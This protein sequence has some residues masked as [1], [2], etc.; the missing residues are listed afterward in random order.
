MKK[1]SILLFAVTVIS[2]NAFAQNWT[3]YKDKSANFSISVPTTPTITEDTQNGLRRV[4][5]EY[6]DY[7]VYINVYDLPNGIKG[8]PFMAAANMIVSGN[9]QQAKL[10]R[11]SDLIIN[12]QKGLRALFYEPERKFYVDKGVVVEGKNA[13]SIT[14]IRSNQDDTAVADK[15][16]DSINK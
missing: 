10:I 11:K 2:A 4:K 3:S 1:F 9:S 8:D 7:S 6:G 14:L 5:A 12:G 13:Y 15:M 16:F